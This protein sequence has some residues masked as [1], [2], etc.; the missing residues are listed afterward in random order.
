MAT[1]EIP[2]ADWR[3]FLDDFSRGHRAW[4]ATVERIH[5]A[6]PGRVEAAARPLE[7]VA[8]I[9]SARRV[10]GIEV[11][12]QED[13]DAREAVRIEAPVKMRVDETPER[14]TRGLEIEGEDGELLRIRFRSAP[15]SEMLDGVAPAEVSEL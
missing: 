4:L 7:T 1:R 10:V 15:L 12:F 6:A 5:P 13:S 11:R 3:P 2:F 14:T 9:E 8:P